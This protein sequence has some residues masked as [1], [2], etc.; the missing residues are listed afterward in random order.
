MS[1][2]ARLFSSRPQTHTSDDIR[3]IIEHFRAQRPSFA[4]AQAP[5]K[6]SAPAQKATKIDLSDLDL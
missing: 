6:K 4:S 3:R 1:D 5:A 2:I